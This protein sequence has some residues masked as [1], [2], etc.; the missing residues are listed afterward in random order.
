MGKGIPCIWRG[1][2]PPFVGVGG[3]HLQCNYYLVLYTDADAG[4]QEYQHLALLLSSLLRF[5]T[6]V[7]LD[8][9]HQSFFVFQRLKNI[10][11]ANNEVSTGVRV[12]RKTLWLIGTGKKICS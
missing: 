7:Y 10:K 9:F 3:T 6:V 1:H 8:P 2:L 11:Y 5:Y 12:A 4:N